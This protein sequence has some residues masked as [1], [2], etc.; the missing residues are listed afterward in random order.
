[1]SGSR[2]LEIS[3][4]IAIA[5]R[6]LW[7]IVVPALILPVLAYFVSLKIPN[8]FTSQTLILVEQQKVPDTYVKP[9]ITEELNARLASMREQ[10]LSRSR[11]EPIIEKYSLD[12]KSR[13][14]L[15]P[16]DALDRV[17]KSIEITPIDSDGRAGT[18]GFFI[19]FSWNEARTAQQVCGEIASMFIAENLRDRDLSVQGTT[20][21]LNSQLQIAKQKL[22]EQDAALAGF[23]S[24]YINQLPGRD[25]TNM[26]MLSSLNSQLD[27]T[28][29]T[30]TQAEQQRTYLQ[31]LLAQQISNWKSKQVDG[32]GD[33][34]DFQKRRSALE[35]ELTRLQARYTPDHPDVI[36]AQDALKRL[37]RKQAEASAASAEGKP[38]KSNGPE[39]TEIVQ[40]RLSVRQLDDSISNKKKE[41]ERIQQE[42]RT[43]QSR[44]QLSP[45]VEEQYKK[46]TR[47]YQTAQSF[48]EELLTKS[49]QSEMATELERQKQGE[50]FRVMDAPNLPQKPTY[51]NRLMIV[52]GGLGAGLVVGA[53]GAT[54]LEMRDQS[55][56]TEQDVSFTLKLPIL[57]SIPILG[58][59]DIV[60]GK[61]QKKSMFVGA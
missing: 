15:S 24:K 10:I 29:Q 12:V 47:D 57:A 27:V 1:M 30:I 21:F 17:R 46:L 6:R 38:S 58:E 59:E 4:Y 44:I 54:V 16:D 31:S 2:E 55:L 3:D 33:P 11:L 56:R 23:K 41:Q 61:K 50:Q 40:L 19:A 18:P 26:A 53:G 32:A 51:P 35:A 60:Q 8:R 43:Y 37:D 39:P 34:E 25:E 14:K 52:M 5:R 36:K 20:Q 48:Y 49:R 45:M 22:D 13:K 9:V 42:I 28:I 7:I